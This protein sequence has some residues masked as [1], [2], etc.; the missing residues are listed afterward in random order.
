MIWNFKHKMA[1]HNAGVLIKDAIRVA[2]LTWKIS[3]DELVYGGRSDAI[4]KMRWIVFAALRERKLTHDCIAGEFNM[5]HSTIVHAARRHVECMHD[6]EYAENYEEFC[7][8]FQR[9][10]YGGDPHPNCTIFSNK[11]A[12]NA[13]IGRRET[14]NLG[15]FTEYNH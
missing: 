7:S 9:V 15:G 14:S 13:M 10:I 5:D 6:E 12:P 3:N 2:Y 4:V 11:E 8:A 1:P